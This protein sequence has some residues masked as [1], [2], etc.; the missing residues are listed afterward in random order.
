MNLIFPTIV[1][2]S[3]CT[4]LHIIQSKRDSKTFKKDQLDYFIYLYIPHFVMIVVVTGQI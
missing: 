2:V 3:S 4:G 1:E